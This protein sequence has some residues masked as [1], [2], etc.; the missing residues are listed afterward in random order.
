MITQRKNVLNA[1][2]VGAR[3]RKIRNYFG[4]NQEQMAA[5]T[6]ILKTTYGKNERGDHIIQT[7]SLAAIHE[8]MGVSAEWLL[9]GRAPVF[10]NEDKKRKDME[11]KDENR[12]NV[13][14]SGELAEMIDAVKR[15]P[16]LRHAV[17][18]HFQKLKLENQHLLKD[19]S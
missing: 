10:W 9:F 5:L 1:K 3:L 7:G 2:T 12:E 17:L 4:Y 19:N 11:F 15:V 6:G 16:F 13:P 8:Q 14:V 18:G